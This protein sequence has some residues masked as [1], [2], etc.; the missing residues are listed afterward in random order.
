MSPPL[1]T[2]EELDEQADGAVPAI[3]SPPSV[4][5]TQHEAHE[6]T[7]GNTP[8]IMQADA[9]KETM[10]PSDAMHIQPELTLAIASLPMSPAE[11]E[12]RL[13]LIIG[14]CPQGSTF[15]AAQ[16]FITPILRQHLH[17]SSVAQLRF[18]FMMAEL[19]GIDA[20]F[21]A[22]FPIDLH[23]SRKFDAIGVLGTNSAYL[24]G[25]GEPWQGGRAAAG[26]DCM[27]Q[28]LR[29][30]AQFEPCIFFVETK[31][32]VEVSA[33]AIGL[34]T[35]PTR[36]IPS[37]SSQSGPLVTF[38]P[39][40]LA[41]DRALAFSRGAHEADS[42]VLVAPL[43]NQVTVH[44]TKEWIYCT[45]QKLATPITQA[46]F[47]AA[48][49]RRAVGA[50][51]E[52]VQVVFS[53]AESRGVVG[54]TSEQAREAM[55][56][57]AGE[58]ATVMSALT[59]KHGD[60]MA[61]AGQMRANPKP[62]RVHETAEAPNAQS[63][64]L[65]DAVKRRLVDIPHVSA[66][67]ARKL[68]F[69]QPVDVTKTANAV[70]N[71][72][73]AS[74]A[75][76]PANRPRVRTE[77]G[78]M[79]GIVMYGGHRRAGDI[80]SQAEKRQTKCLT[81]DKVLP[82]HD[83]GCIDTDQA[84]A[85]A[86]L[87]ASAQQ[88]NW[89]HGSWEC[90]S[91]SPALSL[92][93]GG[94]GSGREPMGPYRSREEYNGLASLP[95]ATRLR[96]DS[97]TNQM[98]LFCA[99]ALVIHDQGGSVTAE[100][101]PDA[102]DPK[103]PDYQEYDGYS[104]ATQVAVWTHPTMQK[105]IQHTGSRVIVVPLC[106]NSE[107][108]P[109]YLNRKAFL[110]NPAAWAHAAVM[111]ALR[112]TH[113]WHKRMTG[114]AEDGRTHG[115]H[116][117]EYSPK[118]CEQIV[119]I[120]YDA[121]QTR[122]SRIAGRS[123]HVNVPK[124]TDDQ[125]DDPPPEA[126][127]PD[128][129]DQP[130]PSASHKKHK[131]ENGY[132]TQGHDSDGPH[133]QRQQ[134]HSTQ[135]PLS[136][137]LQGAAP[138]CPE[139]GSRL[140]DSCQSWNTKC[141][142]WRCV[143][144][145][146]EARRDCICPPLQAQ[147]TACPEGTGCRVQTPREM[148]HAGAQDQAQ[149]ATP[150]SVT[151]P[152][153]PQLA[154]DRACHVPLPQRKKGQ[155]ASI[156]VILL[157]AATLMV[158]LLT[159]G[160][161]ARRQHMEE[162]TAAGRHAIM[163]VAA[164][165]L[166]E[167]GLTAVQ[168]PLAMAGALREP[169]DSVTHIVVALADE[170]TMA[171]EL[172]PYSQIHNDQI[173]QY[174]ALAIA[175][176]EQML[177]RQPTPELPI[178]SNFVMGNA[179]L[180][181]VEVRVQAT[182]D[183]TRLFEERN[184]H[185]ARHID[186]I[187]QALDEQARQELRDGDVDMSQYLSETCDKVCRQQQDDI[188]PEAAAH[189]Q[190]LE[191]WMAYEPYA[192]LETPV[193]P[194]NEPPVQQPLKRRVYKTIQEIHRPGFLERLNEWLQRAVQWMIA[195]A[196]G[197]PLPPRPETFVA[198]NGEA[199]VDECTGTIWD[200]RR[201][202]EQII[203]PLDFTSAPDSPWNTQWL[204]EAWRGY[205]DRE[206]V[207]HACDGADLRETMPYQYCLSPHLFSL[208]DGYETALSDLQA[209]R[210]EGYCAWF[211]HLAFCPCRVNAQGL[212]NEGDKMR[213][214][215]AGC[216]PFE[217]ILD[218]H[219][220]WCRSINADARLLTPVPAP[221]TA[222]SR[223]KVALVM[224]VYLLLSFGR[225]K[226]RGDTFNERDRRKFRKER[227]PRV[228][229]A[230]HD[231]TVM[232]AIA[233]LVGDA[234]YY[235]SDDFRHFFYQ[236]RVCVKS[237]WFCGIF[238]YDPESAM[239]VFVVE[240]A[241]AMGYTQSSNIA[242]MVC[243]AIL[244]LFDEMMEEADTCT[245][246]LADIL[247][248]RRDAHGKRHGRAWSSRGYT[249]DCF[250][251]F[252][253]V[254]RT[255]L[256][257][258]TWRR[259][260]RTAN[261]TGAKP[262]KRQAGTR[263]LFLGVSLLATALFA[264]VP[265][266]KM[267]RAL[268]G[269][270]KLMAG[271]MVKDEAR[272]LFG[273]LVHLSFLST[274]GR[275][276]TAGMWRCLYRNRSDPVKLREDERVRPARWLRI[277]QRS[278][279]APMDVALR[280]KQRG[281]Q[282]VNTALVSN[283]QSD[284]FATR[285]S[286]AAGCGGYAHGSL[287]EIPLCGALTQASIG[288][289]ELL[290][291]WLH[292]VI[293]EVAHSF[294]AH[295]THFM[296]NMTAYLVLTQSAAREALLQWLY[297]AIT[298]DA[299]FQRVAHKLR[300]GQR[301][302]TWLVLADSAS[303]G[304]RALAN[305]I[306][307][308]TGVNFRWLTIPE[309][310]RQ[311]VAAAEAAVQKIGQHDIPRSLG[312]STQ[313]ACKLFRAHMARR[314][315]IGVPLTQ[316]QRVLEHTLTVYGEQAC[317][318]PFMAQM[319]KVI[320]Q[321]PAIGNAATA[322]PV[323][324]S[325][326]SVQAKSRHSTSVHLGLAADAVAHADYRMAD[327]ADGGINIAE[328]E[329][330]RTLSAMRQAVRPET[331]VHRRAA[332]MRKWAEN[333]TAVARSAW[334]ATAQMA[335]GELHTSLLMPQPK[336]NQ[337]QTAEIRRVARAFATI[338]H[339]ADDM[340][341]EA[342]CIEM[343]SA[344][345]S[346]RTIEQLRLQAIPIIYESLSRYRRG[347]MHIELICHSTLKFVLP[348]G[349]C[350]WIT[351]T[352]ESIN[353]GLQHG[354]LD[355]AWE[356]DRALR[357]VEV[358]FLII[359]EMTTPMHVTNQQAGSTARNTTQCVR[360]ADDS[361]EHMDPRFVS[362]H[363]IRIEGHM[364]TRR[365]TLEQAT[366][367]MRLSEHA[368]GLPSV[369]LLEQAGSSSGDNTS[370]PQDMEVEV[371][372]ATP[373][374]EVQAM[375]RHP[376]S[377]HLG[378]A[379]DSVA[380]PDYDMASVS[381]QHRPLVLQAMLDALGAA[382]RQPDVHVRHRCAAI[383]AAYIK[384]AD[385]C[386]PATLRGIIAA[387]YVTQLPSE[388]G[389]QKK[390]A[391][392]QRAAPKTVAHHVRLIH[393]VLGK[394][395]QLAQMAK[396]HMDAVA[397]VRSI[398]RAGGKAPPDTH[399]VINGWKWK[400]EPATHPAVRS[401]VAHMD[402]AI[403]LCSINR[404]DIRGAQ[405]AQTV[406]GAWTAAP[407]KVCIV[408]AW[409]VNG[410]YALPP[411]VRIAMRNELIRAQSR[412]ATSPHLGN[413]ADSI[414]QADHDMASM[415]MPP[416]AVVEDEVVTEEE[417]AD[418]E[419]V[420]VMAEP[421]P[422]CIICMEGDTSE[423]EILFL[424]CCG[425]PMHPAC[426][427]QHVATRAYQDPGSDEETHTLTHVPAKCPGCNVPLR[428]TTTRGAL[429]QEPPPPSVP[430]SPPMPPLT[431]PIPEVLNA[432]MPIHVSI[433]GPV[434]VGKSTLMNALSEKFASN[435]V[436]FIQEPLQLWRSTGM[437][438]RYYA[439]EMSPL[440][441]QMAALV[442]LYAPFAQA[443]ATP[444]IRVVVTERSL[445][446]NLEVF[447]RLNLHAEALTDFC[448]TYDAL[449]S[450]LPPRREVLIY[451]QAHPDLLVER[452]LERGR[453][454][455]TALDAAFHARLIQQHDAMC[456]NHQEVVYIDAQHSPEHV[457][458]LGGQFLASLLD[459]RDS[460]EGILQVGERVRPSWCSLWSERAAV[461]WQR[462][463]DCWVKPNTAVAAA[464]YHP[465][466]IHLG[467]HAD[468]VAQPDYDMASVS[469]IT[470]RQQLQTQQAF[471]TSPEP[472]LALTVL[473]VGLPARRYARC[474][475]RLAI[476]CHNDA[477]LLCGWVSVW[478][479]IGSVLNEGAVRQAALAALARKIETMRD[480]AEEVQIAA[481]ELVAYAA[482][483]NKKPIGVVTDEAVP[484]LLVNAQ[485]YRNLVSALHTAART[486]LRDEI[487]DVGRT[488]RNH[489]KS[490]LE[491]SEHMVHLTICL[492]QAI[493]KGVPPQLVVADAKP[494]PPAMNVPEARSGWKRKSPPDTHAVASASDC[495][496]DPV[497]P[498][499]KYQN[500]NE[501]IRFTSRNN[502]PQ[503]RAR[504]REEGD[505]CEQ[506]TRVW[507]S[508]WAILDQGGT[509]EASG[510][511]Y[512]FVSWQPATVLNV[513]REE[514]NGEVNRWVRVTV[515]W[516]PNRDYARYR[517]NRVVHG[518]RRP[519][520][521]HYADHYA[522]RVWHGTRVYRPGET[523]DDEPRY[524][525]IGPWHNQHDYDAV[526]GDGV[527]QWLTI[528]FSRYHVK[529]RRDNHNRDQ[530]DQVL[531]RLPAPTPP[532]PPTSP[533]SPSYSVTPPS[534]RSQSP[535]RDEPQPHAPPMPPP[536][537]SPPTSPPAPPIDDQWWRRYLRFPNIVNMLAEGPEG[538]EAEGDEGEEE[539]S[540]LAAMHAIAYAPEHAERDTLAQPPQDRQQPRGMRGQV[541]Q[542][543]TRSLA[544]VRQRAKAVRLRGSGDMVRAQCADG[545]IRVP[546]E[547]AQQLRLKS[548]AVVQS[549]LMAEQHGYVTDATSPRAKRRARS[550]ARHVAALKIQTVRKGMVIRRL[551][552]TFKKLMLNL[553]QLRMR[554]IIK[555]QA[556]A[557]MTIVR[558][559]WRMLPRLLPHNG[560]IVFADHGLP[561]GYNWMTVV[562]IIFYDEGRTHATAT[563]HY[564]L[565]AGLAHNEALM[566]ALDSLAEQLGTTRDCVY[567]WATRG[568]GWQPEI[569]CYDNLL[570]LARNGTLLRDAPLS[571]KKLCTFPIARNMVRSPSCYVG[572]RGAER[573]RQAFV[574]ACTLAS[575]KAMP[576][577]QGQN[578]VPQ[579]SAP[580]HLAATVMI[581]TMLLMAAL[582]LYYMVGA[583]MRKCSF[584]TPCRFLTTLLAAGRLPTANAGPSPPPSPAQVRAPR[585]YH[586]AV[587]AASAPP[588]FGSRKPRH[589]AS[590]SSQMQFMHP[591]RR[592]RVNVA[593]KPTYLPSAIRKSRAFRHTHVDTD[594]VFGHD[595]SPFALRGE[596]RYMND[597][598]QSV[599][600]AI[601][602]GVN[603]RT[604]NGEN[605]A[606][607][608]YYV[609]Y[610]RTMRTACWRQYEAWNNPAREA[611]FLSGFVMYVWDHMRPRRKADTAPRVDSVRSV[612]GHVRRKHER[613]GQILVSTTRVKHVLKGLV[614]R[615]IRDHGLALPVRAEPFTAQ[616]KVKM[617][618]IP[619]GAKIGHRTYN[620]T[621]RFWMGWRL[622]DLMAGQAGNRKS[623]LVGSQDISFMR[624]NIIL[625][626]N[627]VPIRDPSPEQWRAAV[628]GRDRV[629]VQVN[630]SKADADGSKFGPNLI[631]SLYNTSN[632][633]SFAAAIIEYELAYPLRGA[634]RS[635]AWL[636][637][638]D[639]SN[640]W[641]ESLID[642]TLRS[643]MNYALTPEE[644]RH[645]S[646]HSNRVWAATA[647]TDRQSTEGEVQA[648]VR[649]SSVESLRVYA[650]MNHAYQ[651]RKRDDM[652][653]ANVQ[654]VNATAIPTVDETVDDLHEIEAM[655]DALDAD[656]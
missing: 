284:A 415:A 223:W 18:I 457:A 152:A 408:G 288:F 167:Y 318:K 393:A 638:P 278:A 33:E 349:V 43:L 99:M 421:M 311:V 83:P 645:K 82:A 143:S 303:R 57:A 378:L 203:C 613:R 322:T 590:T 355:Y 52:S 28:Y 291:V 544:H 67:E 384:A 182:D 445:R 464:S 636:F 409:S 188:P 469:V 627:E 290:A 123:L 540:Q 383:V 504:T 51:E 221:S 1:P 222:K 235:F 512:A 375:S 166:L 437:L 475:A 481:E 344:M 121:F 601:D 499:N 317:T 402:A 260:L 522:Q 266:H 107:D 127:A 385:N 165:L 84:G 644:R 275:A 576:A 482:L 263:V 49:A 170:K 213:R 543:I 466:S 356:L 38:H 9:Q 436:A 505:W 357:T 297:D 489:L 62:K 330:A 595:E 541:R 13:I 61:S 593:P 119:D 417:S 48:L 27:L 526:G 653:R 419:A 611:A 64:Y 217:P 144:L 189:S 289:L 642:S 387:Y 40:V 271:E 238:I 34:S 478:D 537:P 427:R 553:G 256:G 484:A 604:A 547:I 598:L 587:S 232:G 650:R 479:V 568:R 488:L 471:A 428:R 308:A 274:S 267:V 202:A 549:L 360:R 412:H 414:A 406:I 407:D 122:Q 614:R 160:H 273:L 631:V 73:R 164:E 56:K 70:V 474:L 80:Q 331:E 259:L 447:A 361:T 403:S 333:Y 88:Y 321:G 302:G 157:T 600:K 492:R 396:Q 281:R 283:N 352:V 516:P 648:L 155:Q 298:R 31:R 14:S 561:L 649:W 26:L 85:R 39:E 244:W 145:T 276:S 456:A 501:V 197:L 467:L 470:R 362:L 17:A 36:P 372:V 255:V 161:I 506:G 126:D 233:Q 351:D 381:I 592:P 45:P 594:H 207:S 498:H 603:P 280:R 269:L 90:F 524:A 622:V 438:R 230:M 324:Q 423:E 418:D 241:L 214:V 87:L 374:R 148:P 277:L 656:A 237:L 632:P 626:L 216:I 100:N 124:G 572:V 22:R 353:C 117:Q 246:A 285:D 287:W 639:G 431:L 550:K 242:Q 495:A 510:P 582:A 86:A 32:F 210:D 399:A 655:A 268:L 520:F 480:A 252:I 511:G 79:N 514:Q 66:K 433:E 168:A 249:D 169:D 646:F 581:V 386:K 487:P 578:T 334:I 564:G 391:R 531:V 380:H 629:G 392:A 72:R 633:L 548:A 193:T 376:T 345:R 35:T 156:V 239:G 105:F 596:P 329:L 178:P 201:A 312:L 641:T 413:A 486:H 441:F 588:V 485:T 340:R 92:P 68:R 250:F 461:W 146:C 75:H 149:L 494:A 139:C 220:I 20:K 41:H 208:A 195:A 163:G 529:P 507:V 448:T 584:A 108:D 583:A 400:W 444:G 463:H 190:P 6:P 435:T 179:P 314:R 296:D 183:G 12:Q 295:V 42:S 453:P 173:R 455:E 519:Q 172:K 539:I 341:R 552:R 566:A 215:A 196:Q 625:F 452:V 265:E 206:A 101:S 91:W 589:V 379:A 286:A 602:D 490:M 261:I 270:A 397:T 327:M 493:E 398:V 209:L 560:K 335:A 15:P 430:P 177:G 29:P 465:T 5:F 472:P 434:G 16:A 640:R 120:H 468:S 551:F 532:T 497:V 111:A 643:V 171:A 425:Q 647:F 159:G 147:L 292:I 390:A 228:Q 175:S 616:E 110:F 37:S 536:Y 617:A 301:W 180:S 306:G 134:S 555:I 65:L 577:Q 342:S 339:A 225:I 515:P 442:T 609:P 133:G 8:C 338:L 219:G 554:S 388:Y 135:V 313:A 634:A 411:P 71:A 432:Q 319:A 114:L 365:L 279:A 534:S 586:A 47:E 635:K 76:I 573:L 367:R 112:C 95:T 300:F 620:R 185:D 176:C 212:V 346:Q 186:A 473:S 530:P 619:D 513:W 508:P 293:N 404:A 364:A 54:L 575:T 118:T 60:L 521:D 426:L 320:V 394:E 58:A 500:G 420:G 410:S 254:A 429:Q 570:R 115:A 350:A 563:L 104:T 571:T 363:G 309:E 591:S 11:A 106:P 55:A 304:H 316:G 78:I 491:P 401:E 224:V 192:I 369:Q 44:E 154:E 623:E 462:I 264:Y 440:E 389:T 424:R 102:S 371:S 21:K 231:S 97:S 328:G 204:R 368:A 194:P 19:D 253:G 599:D 243:D 307:H 248:R 509:V 174:V 199:F 605:S 607:H 517:S 150:T 141:G 651:A 535:E 262:R 251:T 4:V 476:A 74:Y 439:G 597:L 81:V 337:M 630:I 652:I 612:L 557:R 405:P 198:S 10:V 366:S 347:L 637:T 323:S 305:Q 565:E 136:T 132:P 140:L 458:H 181:G 162:F 184:V 528:R 502:R 93:P 137:P 615:R 25:G 24:T 422:D 3:A 574:M 158:S 153:T 69:A 229:D 336:L 77:P 608:K 483:G 187:R 556:F 89:I 518:W 2:I 46:E 310:A 542:M 523:A 459:S 533:E 7:A 358:D 606:W 226:S 94:R 315:H 451:L 236:L 477:D 96:V 621:S 325:N 257:I 449:L 332:T 116:A 454:E 395:R 496:G 211:K 545:R 63:I 138:V 113:S 580:Y 343:H 443:M 234:V 131:G 205:H 218:A 416:N 610:C 618:N 569:V 326:E 128:D 354:A 348:W 98:E 558:H 50:S 382:M 227:K 585:R 23:P 527:E 282:P 129:P 624:D 59:E 538:Q 200:C 628:S 247:K 125:P 359:Q 654:S 30:S 53:H 191:E 377:V 258:K 109:P 272:R 245:A 370:H 103:S 562:N 151:T 503:W 240:L 525:V 559:R 460:L 450:T 446:S 130:Q 142:A 373:N 546:E 294:A 567:P 579:D 299:R